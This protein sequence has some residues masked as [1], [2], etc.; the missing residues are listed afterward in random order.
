MNLERTLDRIYVATPVIT[1]FSAALSFL[2]LAVLKTDYY[3]EIFIS[4]WSD[5]STFKGYM[6]M[7]MS[8]LVASA[9]EITRAT[10]FILTYYDFKKGNKTG[11]WLG[12]IISLALVWYDCNSAGAISALWTGEH[13]GQIGN[14][15]RDLVIFLTLLGFSLEFRVTLTKT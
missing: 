6:V 5:L 10:L 2:I 1:F 15:I 9:T 12:L 3:N 4:R 8:F 14:I 11:G 13:V 7:L